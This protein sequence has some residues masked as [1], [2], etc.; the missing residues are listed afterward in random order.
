MVNIPRDWSFFSTIQWSFWWSIFRITV[1]HSTLWWHLQV[2]LSVTWPFYSTFV[3]LW[4]LSICLK[5]AIRKYT[6][7]GKDTLVPWDA[8]LAGSTLWETPISSPK[9]AC[10]G[11]IRNFKDY[12][13]LDSLL[14]SVATGTT[15]VEP[16]PDASKSAERYGSVEIPRFYSLCSY[17]SR[18]VHLET[19]CLN[20]R[21]YQQDRNWKEW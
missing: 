12:W 17:R 18:L 19:L 13:Y 11:T 4:L 5:N 1:W 20:I 9:A 14:E 3:I 8:P 15:V 7:Q 2:K 21:N 10:F 16:V 6:L